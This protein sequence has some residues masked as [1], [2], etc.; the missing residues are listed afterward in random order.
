MNKIIVLLVLALISCK[1]KTKQQK[2]EE[3]VKEYIH[4]SNNPQAIKKTKFT[5]LTTW[6]TSDKYQIGVIENK[7]IYDNSNQRIFIRTVYYMLDHNLT[8]VE[9]VETL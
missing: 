7:W 2:A 5:E 9:S 6:G 8:R 4:I 1:Q 3:L